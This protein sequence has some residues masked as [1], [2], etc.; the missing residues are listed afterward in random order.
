MKLIVC[1]DDK[2]GMLFNHRRQSADNALYQRIAAMT[3]GD[4]LWVNK[5]SAP[6]FVNMDGDICVHEC[7]LGKMGQKDWCFVENIELTPYISH[8][9]EIVIFRW[10]RVY[11]ADMRFP[12]QLLD[13]WNLVESKSFSGHSHDKIT[14]EVYRR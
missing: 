1:L 5:Y 2:N 7:F 9:D 10:N 11:P 8:M 13:S 3:K 12:M 6:L 14:R 4:V